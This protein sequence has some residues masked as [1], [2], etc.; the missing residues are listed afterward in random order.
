VV[1]INLTYSP[2]PSE[3][4]AAEQQA[5]TRAR[6]R[7]AAHRLAQDRAEARREV[8]PGPSAQDYTDVLKV[9]GALDE[10]DELQKESDDV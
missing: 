6:V 1:N 7:Y 9:I 3:E 10:Y 8:C 2:M 4:P 5:E